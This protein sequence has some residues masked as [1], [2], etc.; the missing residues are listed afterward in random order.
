MTTLVT[1]YALRHQRGGVRMETIRALPRTPHE[2]DDEGK[3]LCLRFGQGW[4]REEALPLELPEP[5]AAAAP[6]FVA[7]T[8]PVEPMTCAALAPPGTAPCSR[9][10]A[11]GTT[12]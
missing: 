11:T 7:W 9:L 8:S 12:C 1:V 2:L 4:V 6:F 5:V 3:A 10:A